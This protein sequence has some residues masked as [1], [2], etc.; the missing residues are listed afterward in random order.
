MPIIEPTSAR[1][2]VEDRGDVLVI[3]VPSRKQWFS[4]AFLSFWLV[5][6]ALG[7]IV[8]GSILLKGLLDLLFGKPDLPGASGVAISGIGL[9]L[10][11]WF[12]VW[13]M[14]GVLAI[15]TFFWQIVG[16]EVIEV[17]YDSISV[18]RQMFGLGLARRQYLAE[19]IRELRVSLP[20]YSR[21]RQRLTI[22]W[23]VDG[24]WIAF[25]YGA[26]TV[27]FAGEVDEAEAKQ[28]VAE[29]QR[30]YPQYR[31]GEV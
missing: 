14:G 18:R 11:A 28:I 20:P 12:A 26:K 6:W 5:G 17:R 19:S 9:F 13:T 8:V 25:D 30:H 1:H 2:T 21:N 22:P 3:T 23:S 15:S 27:R 16:R 29:V 31:G 10:L 24:G 4:T 7:E